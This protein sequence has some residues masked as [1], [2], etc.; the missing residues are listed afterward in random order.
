VEDKITI[1]ACKFDGSIHRT[2]KA[3]LIKHDPPLIVL[4][5]VFDFEINHPSLGYIK[6]GTRS[7]EY[8]WSDRW[9]NVFCFFEPDGAFRNYYCNINIPPEFDGDV[10]SFIDLDLDILVSDDWTYKILDREEF[11]TNSEKFNYPNNL[12][13]RIEEAMTELLS[14]IQNREFPFDIADSNELKTNV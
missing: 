9:Y 10:L 7:I 5:G 13:M 6:K 14:L 8:H 3:E 11:E 4:D 1:R 12:K 2:W